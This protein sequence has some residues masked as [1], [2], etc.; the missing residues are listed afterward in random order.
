PL[1]DA[2]V[3]NSVGLVASNNCSTGSLSK[4]NLICSNALCCSGPHLNLVSFLVSS[5]IGKFSTAFSFTTPGRTPSADNSKPK[6]SVL[7]TSNIHLLGRN[8][9][10]WRELC[11]SVESD[12]W[13]VPYKLVTKRLGRSAPDLDC[14]SV[15]RVARRLFPSSP[16]THWAHIPNVPQQPAVIVD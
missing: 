2:S 16:E 11:L 10:S 1:Q 8:E 9:D 12:P 14:N 7:F 15:V 3:C 13:G 5:V 4:S 6:H